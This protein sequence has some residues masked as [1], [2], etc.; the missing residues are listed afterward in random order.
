MSFS[1]IIQASNE[2]E[3]T[4]KALKKLGE[5]I[6][7]GLR[8]TGA[9]RI[10]EESTVTSIRKWILCICGHDIFWHD[11]TGCWADVAN[12]KCERFQEAG[13]K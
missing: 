6:Q 2:G 4:E 9:N 13:E 7:S 3:A 8:F 1:R 12:C 5:E 11:N 10:G